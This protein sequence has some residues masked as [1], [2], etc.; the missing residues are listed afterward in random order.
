MFYIIM[1]CLVEGQ[2]YCEVIPWCYDFDKTLKNQT[3]NTNE[4]LRIEFSRIRIK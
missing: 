2:I 1:G 3:K 4:I